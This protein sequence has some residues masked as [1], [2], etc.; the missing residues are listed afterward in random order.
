VFMNYW[1]GL[2]L[3]ADQEVIRHGLKIWS[4]LLVKL[5]EQGRVIISG[6]K[7]LGR[8]KVQELM[9]LKAPKTQLLEVMMQLLSDPVCKLSRYVALCVLLRLFVC[10]ISREGR[11]TPQLLIVT[12][13]CLGCH[14]LLALVTLAIGHVLFSL[15]DQLL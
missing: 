3:S 9:Q 5:R 14:K 7:G 13:R 6:L 10:L 11:F 2:N 8:V 15:L 4:I 12:P 1:A